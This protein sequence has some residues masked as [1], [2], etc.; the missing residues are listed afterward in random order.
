M[1]VLRWCGMVSSLSNKTRTV[2]GSVRVAFADRYRRDLFA[3]LEIGEFLLV[4][5]LELLELEVRR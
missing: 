3:V 4:D 2:L 1:G 5:F